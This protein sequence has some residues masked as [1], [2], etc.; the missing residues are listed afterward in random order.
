MELTDQSKLL[1]KVV[2]QNC[3]LHYLMGRLEAAYVYCQDYE[4]LVNQVD[5]ILER[6]ENM[7]GVDE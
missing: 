2:K 1:M 4:K 6:F 5:A 7:K 3:E